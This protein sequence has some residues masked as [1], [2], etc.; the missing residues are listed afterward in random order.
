MPELVSQLNLLGDPEPWRWA[1]GKPRPL[2]VSSAVSL[3]ESDLNCWQSLYDP[4]SRSNSRERKQV[5]IHECGHAVASF[6]LD[7]KIS[8]VT[9]DPVVTGVDSVLSG[10]IANEPFPRKLMPLFFEFGVFSGLPIQ[11]AL[12]ECRSE[13][14]KKLG[15]WIHHKAPLITAAGIAAEALNRGLVRWRSRRLFL[16]DLLLGQ[17]TGDTAKLMK[18]DDQSPLSW[19]FEAMD[20]IEPWMGEILSLADLVRAKRVISG[21]DFEQACRL[22]GIAPQP[23][24]SP[25]P[26]WAP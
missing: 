10:H 2:R 12:L 19:V 4:Q 13:D 14:V 21:D 8:R 24:R 16:N 15:F 26:G 23:L 25:P 5:A 22:L 18:C 6:L 3:S 9:I 17:S 11:D 20:L 7:V 1:V